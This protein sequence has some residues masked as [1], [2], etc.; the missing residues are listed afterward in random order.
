M[1]YL[2]VP[3][4]NPHVSAVWWGWQWLGVNSE[5]GAVDKVSL[6]CLRIY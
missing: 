2:I 6:S 1:L 3:T 5:L 4:R